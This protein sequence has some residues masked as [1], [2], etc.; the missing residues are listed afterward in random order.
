M[1]RDITTDRLKERL[2]DLGVTIVDLRPIAAYNGWRLAGEARGGHIPGA[3]SFPAAWL[4][5]IE[6]KE[7]DRLLLEKQVTLD[8]TLVLYGYTPEDTAGLEGR[9]EA[10]GHDDVHV[11]GSGGAALGA[12]LWGPLGPP[13]QV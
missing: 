12:G 2:G 5:S 13:P 9:L 6:P 3:V 10:A 11:Y 7:V 4:E 1:T 8:R